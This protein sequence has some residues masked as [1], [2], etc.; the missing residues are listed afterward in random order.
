M[1]AKREC[2]CLVA[3]VL[4]ARMAVLLDEGRAA[5]WLNVPQNGEQVYW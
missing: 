4:A 1:P 2:V 3:A 5:T